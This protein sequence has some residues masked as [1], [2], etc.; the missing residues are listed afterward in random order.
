M[1]NEQEFASARFRKQRLIDMNNL[2]K[3]ALLTGGAALAVKALDSRLEVTYHTVESRLIPSAFD[4]F[5]IVHLSDYHNDTVPQLMSEVRDE[6]PDLIV[7]TGDMADDKGSYAPAVRLVEKLQTVAPCLM[8]SGNHDLWRNDFGS[9]EKEMNAAGAK[10]LHNERVF[11]TKGDDKISVC[12]IDDPYICNE[13]KIKHYIKKAALD[14]SGYDGFEMLLF[15]RANLLDELTG[16]GF[17]LILAGHMHGGH[18]R[19]PGVGGVAAPRTSWQAG[20]GILFPR[21]FGGRFESDGTTMIVNRGLGNP[22]FIPRVFNRPEMIVIKLKK[23][24]ETFEN[25]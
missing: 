4:G 2:F 3:A 19:I 1:N 15:H 12:G 11:I 22:M 7:C 14:V 9:M 18:M 24:I 21:Y 8:V 25:L 10:F 5:K 6:N 23:H 20:E 17:D 13:K 16:F